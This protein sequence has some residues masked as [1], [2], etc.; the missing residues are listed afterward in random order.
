[1][2]Q[3]KFSLLLAM[4]LVFILALPVQAAEPVRPTAECLMRRRRSQ[5]SYPSV[6]G[7]P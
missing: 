5:G 6:R 1:M 3:R 2:K 4:L 7:I